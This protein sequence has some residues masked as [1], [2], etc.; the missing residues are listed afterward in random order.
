MV[1]ML[2][3]YGIVRHVAQEIGNKRMALAHGCALLYIGN[4]WALIDKGLAL[5]WLLFALLLGAM[6]W[7]VYSVVCNTL[8]FC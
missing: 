7:P 5:R 3:I 8:I 4:N 6:A 2:N 1:A